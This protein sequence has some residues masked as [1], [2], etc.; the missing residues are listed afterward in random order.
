[1]ARSCWLSYACIRIPGRPNNVLVVLLLTMGNRH[2][3]SRRRSKMLEIT[4]LDSVKE[5][6]IDRS[7]EG[8]THIPSD[9]IRVLQYSLQGLSLSRN[10]L[11]QLPASFGSL[12]LLI[13]LK[14]DRNFLK[15][16]PPSF[17][18][19][20]Q[21]VSRIFSCCGQYFYVACL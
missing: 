10:Q 1:M 6:A 9:A 21:L 17:C 19:L 2:P 8:I 20:N 7:G 11:Q 18:E 13:E 14:L 4:S 16:L 12:K 15:E 3:T 5:V